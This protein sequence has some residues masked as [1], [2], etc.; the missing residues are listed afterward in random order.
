MEALKQDPTCEQAMTVLG[1]MAC[2][3]SELAEGVS[4][5]ERQLE[6]ARTETEVRMTLEALEVIVLV[7]GE[8]LYGVC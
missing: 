4:W 2:D 5:F 8:L 7:V 6:L 1:Q 3:Q